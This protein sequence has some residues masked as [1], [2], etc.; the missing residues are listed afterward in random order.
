MVSGNG[1]ASTDHDSPLF[2]FTFCALMKA[3]DSPILMLCSII[4]KRTY[5]P[6][7]CPIDTI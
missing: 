4:H 7:S 2:L 3:I 6:E 1:Y 5:H